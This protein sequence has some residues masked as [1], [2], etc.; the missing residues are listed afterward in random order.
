MIVLL[1]T[2][3]FQRPAYKGLMDA[4]VKIR[5]RCSL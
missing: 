3:G 1:W 5:A 4:P 2:L